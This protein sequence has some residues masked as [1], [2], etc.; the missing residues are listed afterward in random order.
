VHEVVLLGPGAVPKTT[1]GKIQRS[2]ARQ[3]WREGRLDVIGHPP[4]ADRP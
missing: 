1:S 4:A 3:L 2:L